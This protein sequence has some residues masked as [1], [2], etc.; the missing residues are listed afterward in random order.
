MHHRESHCVCETPA[1]LFVIFALLNQLS[2]QSLRRQ[3]GARHHDTDRLEFCFEIPHL[4]AS[5]S[6]DAYMV[7]QRLYKSHE[8]RILRA[9]TDD[10]TNPAS[11]VELV[12]NNRQSSDD[13]LGL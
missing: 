6:P 9:Q 4:G 7:R 13:R 3:L 12:E 1:G 2:P 10:N 11:C 5:D 8:H